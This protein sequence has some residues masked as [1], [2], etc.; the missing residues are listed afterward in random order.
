MSQQQTPKQDQTRGGQQQEQQHRQ[1]LELPGN[2]PQ[3]GGNAPPPPSQ[4]RRRAA[5][6]EP[7]RREFDVV[8]VGSGAGGGMAAYVL[9]QAGADV[10]MLEAGPEWYSSDDAAMLTPAYASPRRGAASRYKPFGEFDGCIGGWEVPG[11]P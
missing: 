9:T 10:L 8:I 11:E 6:L 2:A 7:P 4:E 5:V 3:D 1:G